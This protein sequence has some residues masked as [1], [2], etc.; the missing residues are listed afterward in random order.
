MK[1]RS[2]ILILMMLF[3]CDTKTSSVC[4]GIGEGEICFNFKTSEIAIQHWE[5]SGSLFI[6][7]ISNETSGSYY[8]EDIYLSIKLFDFAS[9]SIPHIGT[10]NGTAFVNSSV[11]SKQFEID[12]Y[13]NG[14]EEYKIDL[15]TYPEL[16]ITEILGETLHGNLTVGMV[17]NHNVTDKQTLR[18]NFDNAWHL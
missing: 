3:S 10:Y 9:D 4:E 16:K 12:F 17:N 6:L 13:L 5:K 2:I 14:N 7:E 11:H 8:Q 15:A 18:L 1:H